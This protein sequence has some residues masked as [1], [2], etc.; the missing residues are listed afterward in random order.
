MSRPYFALRAADARPSVLRRMV[1]IAGDHGASLG[2][3]VDPACEIR[4][5]FWFE[6]CPEGI[7]REVLSGLRESGLPVLTEVEAE[8]LLA[9]RWRSRTGGRGGPGC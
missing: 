6:G 9:R 7:A 3:R 8:E 2:R 5:W 1:R 4:D